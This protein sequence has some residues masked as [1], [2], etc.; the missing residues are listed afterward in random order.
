MQPSLE[1]SLGIL[2]TGHWEVLYIQIYTHAGLTAMGSH[3]ASAPSFCRPEAPYPPHLSSNMLISLQMTYLRIFVKRVYIEG[4]ICLWKGPSTYTKEPRV[5]QKHP[6][7]DPQ[8]SLML[9]GFN[10]AQQGKGF[11]TLWP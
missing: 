5:I 4:F 2:E 7:G 6:I 1:L 10:I 11:W 8:R 9:E 3:T